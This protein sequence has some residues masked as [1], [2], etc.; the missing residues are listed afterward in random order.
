MKECMDN[1]R[2]N[3]PLVHNITNY[4]TV[5]DVANILLACG[6]SPIMSDEPEDVEDITSVCGGLNINIGTLH[7]SSIE[8]MLLAGKKANELGHPVLLDPVGAGASRLRTDT[9]LRIMKEIKL[10]VI[11]G[12]ISEIKT[13]AYGSGT[14]KGVDADVADAVTEETLNDA[15]AFVKNFA[16]KTS[17]II[18]VTGAI[19]LVSDGEICYVI[20]N[21]RPEMGKI[22]GTGCQLSGMMTAYVT[23][24]QEKPLE[25][26]AS[27]VCIMGLAGEI[28]W[29]RMQEGDGNATYRNRIIDAVY[30]MTGEDLERGAKYEVR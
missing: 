3:V 17:C 19:D 27:A 25:A 22:T 15:I 12:N 4:V 14:T 23:A 30:Q 2:K 1:V 16:R 29:S 20:R 7:Q 10:T 8:G 9:T 21:G 26:A 13:L 6:G 18:A 24:N 5:N 11:R 28:G